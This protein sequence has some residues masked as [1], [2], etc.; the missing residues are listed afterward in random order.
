M[1][2]LSV[3]KK[4]VSVVMDMVKISHGKYNITAELQGD[5]KHTFK[6]ESNDTPMFDIKDDDEVN[7][8]RWQR[9]LYRRVEKQLTEKVEAWIDM[10]RIED[11][12][13]GRSAAATAEA[14]NNF[15]KK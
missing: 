11:F 8:E 2:I 10:L 9:L 3:Q 13:Q 6:F 12:A 4:E 1:I 14:I 15:S 7:Y 5:I